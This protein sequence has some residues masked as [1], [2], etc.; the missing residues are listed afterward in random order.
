MRPPHLSEVSPAL[1]CW[2]NYGPFSLF[3]KSVRTIAVCN[4]KDNRFCL[5]VSKDNRF[6]LHVSN[7]N[8]FCLHVS[9]DNRFCLHV[10]T[11]RFR[12]PMVPYVKFGERKEKTHLMHATV[13]LAKEMKRL[14]YS[15]PV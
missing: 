15:S 1:P 11:V 9:N 3:L 5:H 13:R 4:S 14:V 10:S 8:R 2:F 12:W 7:D 6:C